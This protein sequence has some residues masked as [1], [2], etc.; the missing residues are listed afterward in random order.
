MPRNHS[1]AKLNL[2]IW[3]ATGLLA[4][5]CSLYQKGPSHLNFKTINNKKT[6]L[7]FY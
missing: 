7:Q 1:L 5:V 6:T 4:M 2:N 3:A